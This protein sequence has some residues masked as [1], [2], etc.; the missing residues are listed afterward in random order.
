MVTRIRESLARN[1][2][3]TDPRGTALRVTASFGL[4]LLDPDAELAE[5]VGRADQAL[6]LAKTAGRNRMIR[7]DASV[8]TSTRW[9]QLQFDEKLE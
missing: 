1:M 6:I 9:R 8:T 2:L 5:C 3:I 7:W 4:A